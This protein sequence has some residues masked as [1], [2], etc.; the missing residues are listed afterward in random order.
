MESA[1]FSKELA[2]VLVDDAQ[3]VGSALGVRLHCEV[4]ELN[5]NYLL[6]S[7]IDHVGPVNSLWVGIGEVG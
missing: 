6:C 5:L 2:S 1:R 4:C 7:Y 3:P